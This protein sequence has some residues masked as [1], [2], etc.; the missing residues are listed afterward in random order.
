MQRDPLRQ[1]IKDLLW[2]KGLTMKEASA[3][4]GRSPS[5]LHQ[6]LER[7]VPRVLGYADAES[8]AKLLGC[9]ASELRH[10]EAP[11]R[12]PQ[13]RRRRHAPP[14]GAPLVAIPEMAVEA[15]AGAGA[16]NEEFAGEKARW[17]LPEGMIRHEGDA[18]PGSLRVLR[19]RGDSMEP[20]ISDGDRL[21]VDLARRTPGTGEM[22]VL[23]DGSGLVV[24][25]VEVMPHE[26][27]PRLRLHSANPEYEP[28]TC[29]A[30]EAHIVGKVVWTL[31]KC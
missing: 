9:K 6:Y 3:A 22:A 16:L 25:R 29:L 31:R 14:P 1:K 10:A 8:L 26:E 21:L 20:L 4:I 11:K 15:A 18:D 23:W 19:A 24:K 27:P 2:Q 17:Y 28:Y 30:E 13:K 5:Y 12:R 7:G